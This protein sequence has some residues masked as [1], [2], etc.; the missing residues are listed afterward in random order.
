M[1]GLVVWHVNTYLKIPIGIHVYSMYIIY[2]YIYIIYIYK[3][4]PMGMGQT[5][6]NSGVT[7][8]HVL[9]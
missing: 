3:R 6:I 8:V 4:S 2:T 5:D 9:R 1:C 7:L